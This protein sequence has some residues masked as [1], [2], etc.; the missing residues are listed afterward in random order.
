MYYYASHILLLNKK[1][2]R[3]I[4]L[5][6]IVT[7]TKH[8]DYPIL[9]Q[10][11]SNISNLCQ[12]WNMGRDMQ[13]VLSVTILSTF[14]RNL[15]GFRAKKP[16]HKTHSFGPILPISAKFLPISAESLPTMY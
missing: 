15:S 6:I 12:N 16:R 2:P 4:I 5:K 14:S 10:Y 1:N 7:S 3:P 8:T 9:V 11:Q 13:K